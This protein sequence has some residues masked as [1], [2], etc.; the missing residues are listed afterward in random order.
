MSSVGVV[1]PTRSPAF[2]SQP[3]RPCLSKFGSSGAASSSS[4]TALTRHADMPASSTS[5]RRVM[6]NAAKGEALQCI[7]HTRGDMRRVP[8]CRQPC[9]R[10]LCINALTLSARSDRQDQAGA[11]SRQGQPFSA[12][13]SR[14]GL[15]GAAR[16]DISVHLLL[17]SMIQCQL[18]WASCSSASHNT[19][20]GVRRTSRSRLRCIVNLFR[21]L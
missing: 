6:T 1:L 3:C 9:F 11:H 19:T 2:R 20:P 10:V 17:G 15:Q 16:G 18:A 5:A 21:G 7:G 4:G 8:S 12:C 14:A 13:R